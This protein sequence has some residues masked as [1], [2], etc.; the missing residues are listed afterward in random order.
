M[1]NINMCG[2]VVDGVRAEGVVLHDGVESVV[3]RGGGG[4]RG[5]GG[6]GGRAHGLGA[7]RRQPQGLRRAGLRVQRAPQVQ[8]LPQPRASTKLSRPYGPEAQPTDIIELHEYTHRRGTT[9]MHQDFFK[10]SLF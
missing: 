9:P 3:V 6:R 5:R 10:I 1:H 4:A 8:H 7:Q 2:G